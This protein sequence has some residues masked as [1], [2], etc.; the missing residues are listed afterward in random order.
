M[1][2]LWKE[3]L[4]FLAVPKTGSTAIEQALAPY[5]AI[6]FQ[7]PPQ[8]KHMTHQRFNRFIRPYLEKEGVEDLTLFAV[9]REPVSWLGSWYRYRQRPDLE[10]HPNSTAGIS[11]NS[12]VTAY[13]ME[14]ERPEYARLGSQARQLSVSRNKVG[15]DLLFRYED[16]PQLCDFLTERIGKK[17]ELAP[18]NISPRA[19]LEL[20]PRIRSRLMLKHPLEFETY[21]SI[22]RPG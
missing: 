11:F 14:G 16:M 13:M 9:M 15:M 20:S 1:M 4:I 12:F 10:G 8:I 2:I 3:R 18:H 17:I 19:E 21:E 5:A 22:R 7:G 6:S